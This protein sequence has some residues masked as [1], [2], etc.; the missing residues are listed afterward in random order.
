MVKKYGFVTHAR[1]GI[2][3]D[4]SN[5]IYRNLN[6]MG[7]QKIQL[8]SICL[9][10]PHMPQKINRGDYKTDIDFLICHPSRIKQDCWESHKKFV[11]E[12]PDIHFYIFALS[13]PGVIKVVGEKDNVSY[14]DGI[15][16]RK[17]IEELLERASQ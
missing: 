16:N 9:C 5:G 2:R 11:E 14:L 17:V 8:G 4:T 3:N 12:N 6:R 7:T 1:S 13:N 15:R 10:D